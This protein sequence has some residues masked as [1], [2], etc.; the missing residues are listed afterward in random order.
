MVNLMKSM[1]LVHAIKSIAHVDS[2]EPMKP[3]N[4]IDLKN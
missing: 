3:T 2:V 1:F 4:L